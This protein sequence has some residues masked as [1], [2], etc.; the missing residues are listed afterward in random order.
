MINPTFEQVQTPM[1]FSV[2]NV[3]EINQGEIVSLEGGV[4][5]INALHPDISK[6]QTNHNLHFDLE[7]SDLDHNQKE[8]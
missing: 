5:T 2:A 1:N 4:N 3:V 6:S 8:V 7:N